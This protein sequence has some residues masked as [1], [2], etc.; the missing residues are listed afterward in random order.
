MTASKSK[1]A[2]AQSGKQTKRYAPA[3]VKIPRKLGGGVLKEFVEQEV[4]SGKIIHY[5]LAYIN[6]AIY[7]GD[8]GSVLGYDNAHGFPHKHFFGIRTPEPGLPWEEI[9]EKFE[10]EWREIALKFVGEERS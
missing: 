6:P 7:T 4:A 9:R 3:D 10:I 1:S 2:K 5:A 8:Q